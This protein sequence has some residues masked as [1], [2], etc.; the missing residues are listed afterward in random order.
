MLFSGH[1]LNLRQFPVFWFV[2]L[3]IVDGLNFGQQLLQR[4]KLQIK[5]FVLLLHSPVFLLVVYEGVLQPLDNCIVLL[6]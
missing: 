4:R 3:Q 1:K 2:G 6:L 5:I